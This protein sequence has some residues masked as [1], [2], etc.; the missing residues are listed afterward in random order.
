MNEEDPSLRWVLAIAL[1]SI[2]IGGSMDL[3]MDQPLTWLSFHVVFELLM[4]AGALTMATTLWLGWRNSQ[5]DVVRL[6]RS[7][8]EQQTE[9][10]MWLSSAR[11]ALDGLARAIDAQFDRWQLT[12][13]EREIALL[14]LKGHSHKAIARATSRSDATVRQHA[15][16]IYHKAG[17]SGRAELAAHFLDDLALPQDERRVLGTGAAPR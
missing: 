9:R 13:A 14:L 16:V 7:L 8:R 15:T 17:L 10:D 1:A 12:P 11:H 3:M 4:I 6:R 5:L 2:I